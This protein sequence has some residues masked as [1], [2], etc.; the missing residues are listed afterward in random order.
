MVKT[1]K[2]SVTYERGN[3]PYDLDEGTLVSAHTHS[4]RLQTIETT[5]V[6]C[7]LCVHCDGKQAVILVVQLWCFKLAV[8][9]EVH[10]ICCSWWVTVLMNNPFKARFRFLHAT[11]TWML[12]VPILVVV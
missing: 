2:H 7:E 5:T 4:S 3:S 8:L 11:H 10:I 9:I 6:S 12:S 1:E